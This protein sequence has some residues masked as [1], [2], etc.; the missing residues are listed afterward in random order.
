MDDS[1]HH[2]TGAADL[3]EDHADTMAATNFAD[4]AAGLPDAS[5]TELAKLAWSCEDEAEPDTVPRRSLRP[6]LRWCMV[7]TAVLVTGAAATWFGTVFYHE[8]KPTPAM[9]P[10]LQVPTP[11]KPSVPPKPPA[12]A[13][14][15][16]APQPSIPVPKAPAPALQPNQRQPAAPPAHGQGGFSAA[17]DQWL[18]QHMRSLGYVILNPSQ[19]IVEAHH[20]CR[21]LQQGVSLYDADSQMATL[22]GTDSIDTGE[23]DSSAMLAYSNCY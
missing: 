16:A 15:P 20:Y 2:T 5:P 9:A 17:E 1:A 22:T 10:T 13:A 19:V 4:A 23:L 3:A 11:P 6:P 21:L 8:E 7:V 14:P 18:L 12:Q